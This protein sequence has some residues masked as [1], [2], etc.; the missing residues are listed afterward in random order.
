MDVAWDVPADVLSFTH[1]PSCDFTGDNLVDFEDFAL[2]TLRMSSPWGLAASETDCTFDL[3]WDRGVDF[4]DLVQFSGH[5]LEQIAC[6]ASRP[7]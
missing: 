7:E 5:W 1:V 4:Y 2:L 3:N 6:D